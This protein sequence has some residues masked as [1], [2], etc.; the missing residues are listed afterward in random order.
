[1]SLTVLSAVSGSSKEGLP[2]AGPEVALMGLEKSVI[3]LKNR[4][5]KIVATLGPASD[6]SE[7]I[8]QML[9]AGANVFRLNMSHGRH[10]THRETYRRIRAA[11][12]KSGRPVGVLVDLCGP[13]IRTGCFPD[14]GITLVAGEPVVVT[15]R[16]VMGAPGLISTI[17]ESF[18]SDVKPGDRIFL[19]DG[20]LELV[21]EVVDGTEVSCRVV[22]GG[23]LG[24]RKGINLPGVALSA[25]A[26]TEKDREDVAFALDLGA[27]MIALSF[28]RRGEEVEQLRHLVSG[29]DRPPY[30]VAKIEKPEA[31]DNI[32]EILKASDAIM[33]ARGDLVVELPP[34][35]V[36]VI[37]NQL[38]DRARAFHKPVIVATQML[39]SM[40]GNVRPT[41]AEVSDVSGA[42]A[43]GA[44]AVMLSA[45]TAAGSHPVES[46]R[47]MDRVAREMENYLW[48]GG[49]HGQLSVLEPVEIAPNRRPINLGAVFGHTVAALSRDLLARAIVVV[50]RGRGS[51]ATILS[52]AR[53]AAPVVAVSRDPR[54]CSWMTLLWGVLPQ[55]VDG[56]ELEEPVDLARRLGADLE[57]TVPGGFLIEV[58]GFT[59][60]KAS[61][62]PGISIIQ[63]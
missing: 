24:D 50:S 26:L 17:Y 25:Q 41:R 4:R 47:M 42:V 55:Q 61:S 10:E 11:A 44:D 39:E 16:Q 31:L 37:Q 62:V 57:L 46:V 48:Q 5:T 6:Q 23:F 30:L 22:R 28:V 13:K 1:M 63:V 3:K 60:D 21:V 36:P 49:A 56:E 51:T 32:D 43:G 54:V 53:P 59:A 19:N 12:E 9:E 8:E 27:D 29:A 40:V 18:A 58:D 15:T 2:S 52:S 35:Q 20:V 7:T 33:V 38:L 34:E 45:E 14:G